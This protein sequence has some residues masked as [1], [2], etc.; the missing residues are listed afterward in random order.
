MELTF[1]EALT[2]SLEAKRISLRQIAERAGVSYE[3][4]KKVKQ[5][6]S[7]STNVDDAQKV[8]KALNLTLDQ[9]L[10]GEFECR[11]AVPVIGFVQQGGSLPQFHKRPPLEYVECPPQLSPH[12][13]Y[14]I[15]LIGHEMEPIYSSQDVLFFSSSNKFR[16]VPDCALDKRCIIIEKSGAGWV[17]QVRAGTGPELYN[18]IALTP[19]STNQHDVRLDWAAPIHLHLPGELV[20]RVKASDLS[21]D[22]L[23]STPSGASK[24]RSTTGE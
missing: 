20:K 9:L 16:G 7:Q 2:L 23:T 13:L 4:L 10:K 8:A 1:A 22:L 14:A 11:L 3:Q 15:R 19:L 5:G 21:F 6:K 18:L 17:K 24:K 12:G